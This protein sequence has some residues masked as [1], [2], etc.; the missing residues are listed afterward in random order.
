MY[1]DVLLAKSISLYIR[2]YTEIY[3]FLELH[4]ELYGSIVKLGMYVVYLSIYSY[5][6]I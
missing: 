1:G 4:M 2:V 5:I 6:L 3:D